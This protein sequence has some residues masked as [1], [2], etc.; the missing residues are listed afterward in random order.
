M[1]QSQ[2]TPDSLSEIVPDDFPWEDLSK[3]RG[4]WVAFSPDGRRLIASS[5]SLA[6]LDARVRAA[7]E[8]PEEVLLERVPDG[9]CIASG[10]ELS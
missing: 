2:Q 7:G 3:H 8:N 5:I 9:D 1:S 4:C 10:T 6:K